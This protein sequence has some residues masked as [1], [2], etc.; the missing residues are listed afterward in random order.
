MTSELGLWAFLAPLRQ[1]AACTGAVS[2]NIIQAGAV[3]VEAGACAGQVRQWEGVEHLDG[4]DTLLVRLLAGSRADWALEAFAAGPNEARL[5]LLREPLADA[6]RYHVL[7]LLSS[8]HGDAAAALRLWRVRVF[9]SQLCHV[10]PFPH[11]LIEA[12]HGQ[13]P[14]ADTQFLHPVK[15]FWSFSPCLETACNVWVYASDMTA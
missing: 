7:A 1:A 9:F 15:H 2:G 11:A 6:H 12:S 8:N 10:L 14:L 13:C 5:D 4:V 3:V